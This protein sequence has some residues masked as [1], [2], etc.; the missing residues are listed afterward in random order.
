MRMAFNGTMHVV[1]SIPLDGLWPTIKCVAE[2]DSLIRA[3]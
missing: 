2:N 3:R 1:E